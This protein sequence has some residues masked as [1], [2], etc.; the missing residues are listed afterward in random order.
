LEDKK[1]LF[2]QLRTCIFACPN[3]IF[4]LGQAKSIVGLPFR[5]GRIRKFHDKLK[6]EI[7]F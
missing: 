7:F 4:K 5:A 6:K 2:F 1:P 3:L